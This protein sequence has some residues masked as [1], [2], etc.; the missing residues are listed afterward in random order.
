MS[1]KSDSISFKVPATIK[2]KEGSQVTTLLHNS[3]LVLL[4]IITANKWQRPI[5]FSTTV[6]D[7]YY[8]GLTN[9][10]KLEGMAQRLVPNKTNVN[11]S[12][13]VNQ[14]ITEKCLLS[15]NTTPHKE[16][17]YGF[18]FRNINDPKI[19]YDEVHQQAIQSYRVLYMKLAFSLSFDSTKYGEVKNVLRKMNEVISPEK[20]KIDYRFKH[21]LALLCHNINDNQ[22][23]VAYAND[24][25]KDITLLLQN[26]GLSSSEQNEANMILVDLYSING[27]YKLAINILNNLIAKYPN[28]VSLINRRNEFLSRM[29][30]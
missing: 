3:A 14:D 1:V 24:G 6:S 19:F 27:K 2:Q 9:Y 25:E 5:Y 21:N 22:S 26:G 11:L 10:L 15:N 4:D 16:P 12:E 28:D 30:K 18:L 20:F 23:A 13:S 7:F 29:P 8:V 17:G